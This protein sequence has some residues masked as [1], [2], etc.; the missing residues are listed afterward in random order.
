MAELL[1]IPS[2]GARAS[3]ADVIEGLNRIYDEGERSFR[4]FELAGGW[5]IM[6]RPE[7]GAL[8]DK[9]HRAHRQSRLSPA[10]METLS[11]IAYR[12]PILRAEIEAIRGV[13]CGEVLRG[14]MERRLLKVTGR[15]EELGRPMLYGTT[16]EFLEIFGL[17]R[18][19]DLPDVAGIDTAFSRAVSDQSEPGEQGGAEQAPEGEDVSGTTDTVEQDTGASA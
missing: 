15:S 1:G 5:Q 13:S 18:I 19:T 9:F 14:L 10:A 17:A 7:Y 8:L 6:T 16:N 3:L 4:I 12:Q 2:A 11:I